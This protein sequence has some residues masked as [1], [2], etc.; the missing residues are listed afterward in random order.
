MGTWRFSSPISI[1]LLPNRE[2]DWIRGAVMID[3]SLLA[4]IGMGSLAVLFAIAS[5]FIL[6]SSVWMLCNQRRRAYQRTGTDSTQ[7]WSDLRLPYFVYVMVIGVFGGLLV[8][9]V[10]FVLRYG[11]GVQ[12]V[13]RIS[14]FYVFMIVCTIVT[15]FVSAVIGLVVDL[16]PWLWRRCSPGDSSDKSNLDRVN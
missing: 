10:A 8:D 13:D 5:P 11:M 1:R 16:A 4:G 14:D 3:P 15:V 12:Q 2:V 6:V 7:K 9:S